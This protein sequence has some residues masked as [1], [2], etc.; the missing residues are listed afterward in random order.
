M[1][2]TFKEFKNKA[3]KNPE[4]RKEYDRLKPLYDIKSKLISLR[5][6]EGLT[7]E[8]IAERM[9]TAKSNISR[10]ESAN[11][12]IMPNVSTLIE[13]AAAMGYDMRIDFSKVRSGRKNDL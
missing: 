7:Q 5:L 6:T 13:Y 11:S 3:L 1:R 9:N 12:K 10:L 2:P 8:D 4:V